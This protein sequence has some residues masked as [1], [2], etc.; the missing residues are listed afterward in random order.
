MD[1]KEQLQQK[2]AELD[3]VI[4]EIN[5]LQ[6]VLNAKNQEA[7]RLDG[8]VKMLNDLIKENPKKAEKQ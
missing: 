1:L 3:G 8:A 6:Q 5:Q 4:K 2:Q 7:L